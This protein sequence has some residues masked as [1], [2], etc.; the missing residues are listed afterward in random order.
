MYVLCN[1]WFR[2]FYASECST[3]VPYRAYI[4]YMV[5]LHPTTSVCVRGLIL[6]GV[7]SLPIA[8]GVSV[9]YEG[10]ICEAPDKLFRVAT[11]LQPLL[12][13]PSSSG[14]V[15]RMPLRTSCEL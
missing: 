9:R 15:A 2:V 11:G 10:R 6:D 12:S 13:G 7:D 1:R 5:T 3:V 8:R 4:K 14:R